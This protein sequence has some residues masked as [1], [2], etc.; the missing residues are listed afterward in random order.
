MTTSEM[1]RKIIAKEPITDEMVQAA[2]HLLDTYTRKATSYTDKLTAEHKAIDMEVYG[3]LTHKPQTVIEICK[4]F[5]HY[6]RSYECKS[7]AAITASLRR[8]IDAGM[9]RNDVC[10][11]KSFYSIAD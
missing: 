6:K 9:A 1:C 2:L 3:I 11:H 7:A 4:T 10:G 5:N 8:L